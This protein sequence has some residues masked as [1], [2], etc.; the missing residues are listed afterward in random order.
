MRRLI[1]NLT[2]SALLL[3]THGVAAQSITTWSE[4]WEGDWSARWQIDADT[5]DV[6]MPGSG[7][8][9]AYAGSQAAATALNG[10]YSEGVDSRLISPPI[11]LPAADQQPRLRFWHWYSFSN[12]DSARVQIKVDDGEWQNLP[13]TYFGTSSDAWS[14]AAIDL[15]SFAGNTV[16][17]AFH[18]TSQQLGN[19]ADVSSGWYLD[20]LAL[21]TGPLA[22]N[23]PEDWESGLGDWYVDQGTW[24]IG[25]GPGSAHSGEK[26]AATV[27]NGNY[28]ENIDSRLISPSF[29]L[30]AADQQPRLRFWH[31]YSFSN[32]DSTRVQIKV[33]DGA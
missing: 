13:P 2:L 12:R 28:H 17:F 16:Q 20:N 31:R 19:N 33:D 23:A 25:G 11:D 18:F 8:A 29:D 27:L 21:V 26:T 22:F 32:L 14:R 3:L 4:D 10:N 15:T 24:E 1:S 30:P 7:P 5:W 6:G 9:K